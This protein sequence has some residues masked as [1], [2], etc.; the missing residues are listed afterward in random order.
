MHM[1]VL[2]E[3]DPYIPENSEPPRHG[4]VPVRF[5]GSYDFAWIESQRALAPFD[6]GYEEK[7]RKVTSEDFLQAVSEAEQFIVSSRSSL[8]PTS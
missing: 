8:C 6:V 1:Q 5:F 2:A 7:K 3:D 4:A